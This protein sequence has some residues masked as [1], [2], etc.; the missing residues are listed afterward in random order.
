MLFSSPTHSFLAWLGCAFRRWWR[1]AAEVRERL[2]R[3]VYTS[4]LCSHTLNRSPL[5]GLSALSPITVIGTF[6]GDAYLLG[7]TLYPAILLG[8]TVPLLLLNLVL[9]SSLALWLILML[10][11]NLK[12][13]YE[14]IEPLSRIQAV[15]C[16]VFL[17]AVLYALVRPR[18]YFGMGSIHN[19]SFQSSEE[20]ASF[21]VVING[22]LLFLMGIA[23]L[24]PPERL[25]VW[26]RTRTTTGGAALSQ[27]GLA[28][29]WLL[30]CGAAVYAVTMAGLLL[31]RHVF[32]LENDTMLAAGLRLLVVLV[33]VMR[34]VS[35]IQWCNLTRL[36]RP[37]VKGFLYLCLYYVSALVIMHVG[38]YVSP[39]FPARAATLLTPFGVFDSSHNSVAN[40]IYAG[41]RLQLAG[42][43]L[44]LLVVSGLIA[45]I[46]HRLS[47]TSNVQL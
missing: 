34:D 7:V 13:D 1:P 28:W 8:R 35:F 27:H 32:P 45:A 3:W 43:A 25:R 23:I 47:R 30:L 39:A 20:L 12:R 5:P 33:F 40:S 16:A 41:L 11:R 37:L 15:A 19:A 18:S 22:L 36:R 10:L 42:I 14:Q 2:Q 6:A 26:W 9:Q 44:Q 38:S 4:W 17:N 24:T 29:P 46:H 21:M 31:W